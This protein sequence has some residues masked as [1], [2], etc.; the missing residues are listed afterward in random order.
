MKNYTFIQDGGI[1]HTS[2]GN[3]SGG[4]YVGFYRYFI[5]EDKT[6]NTQIISMSVMGCA[7][8]RT[9]LIV[10]IDDMEKHHNSL[11]LSIEHY[12]TIADKKLQLWHDGTLTV[13]NKGKVKKQ[14]VLN[15]MKE[16]S[17][18][19]VKGDKIQ[20]GEIDLSGLI[21]VDTNDMKMLLSNLIE[22]ALLRDEFRQSKK[23]S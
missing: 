2:F 15:Y 3:A 7:N 21:Y 23:S 4:S 9:L 10:A 20:L 1:R 19:L 16:N 8:G 11:Q 13:G 12:S 17:S 18:L 22:Y 14:E 6:S 5:I